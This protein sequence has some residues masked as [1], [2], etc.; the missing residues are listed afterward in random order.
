MGWFCR[1][2][3]L[4][5]LFL[6]MVM[7]SFLF[8]D[9][10]AQITFE[11]HVSDLVRHKPGCTA[12]EDGQRLIISDLGSRGIVLSTR[13]PNCS[14]IWLTGVYQYGVFIT[15]Q[16]MSPKTFFRKKKS[17]NGM[18]QSKDDIK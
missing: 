4:S 18:S 5:Y 16:K 12:I 13:S 6:E 14:Q 11:P 9:I 17:P 1:I 15:A 10:Y 7:R 3:L 2:K 8:L